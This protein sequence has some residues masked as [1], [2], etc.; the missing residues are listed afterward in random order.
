[1]RSRA[2]RTLQTRVLEQVRA[3]GLWRPG[4]TVAV[5]VSGGVDSIVLMHLLQRTQRPRRA[6]GRHE[7]QSWSAGG[8]GE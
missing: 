7:H 8:I 2:A 3:Q 6:A 1:M 4:Q 5:G